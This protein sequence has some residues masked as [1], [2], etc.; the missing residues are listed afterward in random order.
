[1]IIRDG[2]YSQQNGGSDN[3]TWFI[4]EVLFPD[5]THVWSSHHRN[6]EDA[7]RAAQEEAAARS[8]DLL[9]ESM[10]PNRKVGEAALRAAQPFQID[11]TNKAQ[12]QQI[13]M[14][15]IEINQQRE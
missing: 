10:W 12:L 5:G 7:C 15:L 8:A 2:T 13:Y 14:Q 1:M 6:V 11:L 3:G 9:T 4:V